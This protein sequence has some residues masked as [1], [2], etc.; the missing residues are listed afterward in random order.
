MEENVELVRKIA[1]DNV[2]DLNE[3]IRE[4]YTDEGKQPIGKEEAFQED[5]SYL[6][7]PIWNI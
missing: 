3:R 7:N 5:Y 6:L 1:N 2:E 4:A